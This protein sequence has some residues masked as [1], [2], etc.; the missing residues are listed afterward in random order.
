MTENSASIQ[1]LKKCGMRHIGNTI[2]DLHAAELFE[3]INPKIN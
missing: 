3:I 1:V 2:C